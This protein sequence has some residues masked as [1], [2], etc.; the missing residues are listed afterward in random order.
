MSIKIGLLFLFGSLCAAGSL[1][2]APEYK[3]VTASEHGTYMQIG[4]DLAKYVATD[5]GINL[6]VLPSNG[7]VDN[8]KRLRDE[9]GTKLALVQSDVY[10]A[11]TTLAAEGNREA[12]RLINPLRIILPLYDEEIYFIARA[13]S[14]LSFIHEIKDK[15]INIG[16][17]GSGSA[18]SSTTL[19]RLMFDG[20]IPTANV[21]TLSNEKALVKLATDNTLEVV[22]VVAGQPAP[23]FSGMEPGV[24]KYFKLLKL[25]PAAP[26]STRVM[27]AY[28]S[29][30]IKTSSYPIWLTQDMPTHSIKTLLVTYDYAQKNTRDNL[31][32]FG[33]SLCNNLAALQK[34]GHPKWRQVS[35]ELPPLEKGRTYFSPAESVLRSCNPGKNKP[36]KDCA[37]EQKVMGLCPES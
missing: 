22:V 6:T 29:A 24:E 4:N 33:K 25:D 12:A 19:Y 2:A 28:P 31:Q 34:V 26:A 18:M 27:D 30:M 16:S 8:V 20:P 5:A 13:D 1:A 37:L 9:P 21:S 15:K 7:S 32:R 36:T 10:Q 17:L 3:I 23:L 35:L 14:P 11:F